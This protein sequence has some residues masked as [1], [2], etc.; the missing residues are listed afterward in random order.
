MPVSQSPCRAWTLKLA[1]GGVCEMYLKSWDASSVSVAHPNVGAKLR[2]GKLRSEART[3]PLHPKATGKGKERSSGRLSYRRSTT[4]PCIS[5]FPPSNAF[6]FTHHHLV[7]SGSEVLEP[8]HLRQASSML[9]S[10]A[11][12]MIRI[13]Q[14]PFIPS[15]LPNR[16]PCACS[17]YT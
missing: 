7:T 12:F 8:Q 5:M 9:S 1:H 6:Y 2:N 13:S 4:L 3:W 17:R 11:R 16:R 14:L 10:L 15:A